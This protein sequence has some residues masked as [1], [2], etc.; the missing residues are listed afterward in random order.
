MQELHSL[1]VR[2]PHIK[3][4]CSSFRIQFPAPK[5]DGSQPLVTSASGESTF[6][7]GLLEYLHTQA[8]VA[9]V[10]EYTHEHRHTHKQRHF[11]KLK[12]LHLLDKKYILKVLEITFEFLN[13]FK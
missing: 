13:Y 8:L 5:F 12:I 3:G 9:C 1:S 11:Q 7:L 6:S 2:Q 10:H 4:T